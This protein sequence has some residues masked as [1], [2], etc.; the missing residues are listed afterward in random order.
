[1]MK[2]LTKITAVTVAAGFLAACGTAD[3]ANMSVKGGDFN[4]GLRDGYVK[5]ANS[6]YDQ[7]D[8]GSGD[9]FSSRAK[10]AAMGKASAPE[11]ISSRKLVAP[12]KGQLTDA[13]ARLVSALG[14]GAAKIIPGDASKAQTSFDCWM[15]QA[16]ENIQPEDIAA[17]R[18]AFNVAMKNVEATLG[19]KKKAK[20]KKKKGP[21]TTRYVVYFDFNSHQLNKA[22]QNAV[23]FVIGEVKKKA[24]IAVTGYADRAGNA[25]YNSILATKRA[26]RVV[27]AFD[28]AGLKNPLSVAVFGEKSPAVNTADGKA[29]RLNRRVE[30]HVTQ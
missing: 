10:M 30:I 1:M 2:L 5:L 18:N 28:K 14:K 29:E 21:Q 6:E 19:P 4:K 22:G 16:E 20:K 23:D 17:C 25:D 3:V 27:A 11:G 8:L 26:N 24:K 7:T 12:H 9:D 15:E 13:R